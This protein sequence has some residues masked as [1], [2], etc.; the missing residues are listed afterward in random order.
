MP[1]KRMPSKR[2]INKKRFGH[3][4]L[5]ALAAATVGVSAFALTSQPA[6]G[7]SVVIAGPSISA[8]TPTATVAPAKV[9]LPTDPRLLFVGDSYT[10]G[11]GADQ[12]NQSWAYLA[13]QDLKYPFRVDG[14]GGTGFAWGGGAK[15][16]MGREYSVRLKEA[17]KRTDF[18]PNVVILQG[19][20]N[21]SLAKNNT[22]VQAAVKQTIEE[23]RQLWPNAQ[24]IVQGPSAPLPLAAD[25]R[26]VNTAVRAGAADA[27][28]PFID[29][30]TE[31][32]FNNSNSKAMNFDGAHV[33]QAGHRLIADKFL[34]AW[35]KITAP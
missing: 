32:W 10:A 23:A 22:A 8:A 13:A 28:A 33:N 20:Q 34:A 29:A 14:V 18:A 19:G 4:G 2:R 6:P 11:V 26:G 7:Q 25:L 9:T 21:D 24:V 5:A 31:G 30:N 12:P 16:D 15:D 17:A 27:K 35:A 1:S 3:I